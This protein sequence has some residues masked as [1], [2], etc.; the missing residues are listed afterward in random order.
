MKNN[1]TIFPTAGR[2]R[3]PCGKCG[4]LPT[5]C[6]HDNQWTMLCPLCD[7]ENGRFQALKWYSTKEDAIRAWGLKQLAIDV[8]GGTFINNKE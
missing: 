3:R 6:R 2:Y 8:L 1:Y 5:L 4:E 7:T